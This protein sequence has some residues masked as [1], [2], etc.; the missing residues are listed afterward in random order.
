[1]NL[2]LLFSTVEFHSLPCVHEALIANL[3]S[4]GSV[5]VCVDGRYLF[6]SGSKKAQDQVVL[7]SRIERYPPTPWLIGG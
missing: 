5:C 1:M 4:L 2:Q 3:A 7:A 6:S